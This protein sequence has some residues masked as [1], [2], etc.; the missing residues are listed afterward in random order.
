[1]AQMLL[2]QYNKHTT[3]ENPGKNESKKSRV[4]IK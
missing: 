1:M 3:H 4:E 2:K